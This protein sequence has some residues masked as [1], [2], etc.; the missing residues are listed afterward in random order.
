MRLQMSWRG[1]Y[2][3]RICLGIFGVLRRQM[4]SQFEEWWEC[5]TPTTIAE[6]EEEV[7]HIV[8]IQDGVRLLCGLGEVARLS[9]GTGVLQWIVQP[10][11]SDRGDARR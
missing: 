1:T 6:M 3:E 5:Y 2:S 11:H 4:F 9:H 10:T 7:T 8:V